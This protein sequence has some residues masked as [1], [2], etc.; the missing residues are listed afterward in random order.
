MPANRITNYKSFKQYFAMLAAFHPDLV[1]MKIDEHLLYEQR[2]DTN[3]PLLEID[4]PSFT[5]SLGND[6]KIYDVSLAILKQGNKNS[7]PHNEQV[8]EDTEAIAS[9]LITVMNEDNI[10]YQ[11]TIKGHEVKVY[12]SDNLW[13]YALEFQIKMYDGHCFHAND[14]NRLTSLTP[15]FEEDE[16]EIS[17]TINGNVY[18]QS[19][20][21]VNVF[22]FDSLVNSINEGEANVIASFT[23]G[24]LLLNSIDLFTYQATGSGHTWI[25]NNWEDGR[26]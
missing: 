10:I 18:T 7:I 26:T 3:Y 17:I 4:R 1:Q 14:W 2:T 11:K 19:W 9:Q 23:E 21:D 25:D 12:T 15:V 13:G 6:L 5:V 8:L 20:E 16:T 24:M 22:N